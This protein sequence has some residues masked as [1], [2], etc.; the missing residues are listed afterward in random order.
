MSIKTKRITI[1]GI[2]QGVGFR[3]FIYRIANDLGVKGTVLNSSIGV[4][5]EANLDDENLEKFIE[6]IKEKKPANSEITSIKIEDIEYKDFNDF[7]II[8]SSKNDITTVSIPVDLGICKD[9]IND[10][11]DTENPRFLYP[12]TNCTNCGPRFSIIE[13]LPYDRKYT[14]MRKFKMCKRCKNEYENPLDRRF[15]A[16]PNACPVCGPYIWVKTSTNKIIEKEPFDYITQKIISGEVVLIKGLGGFHIACDAFNEKAVLELREIKRRDFK[17]FAIMI[18]EVEKLSKWI[19]ITEEEKKLFY[20]QK[21]PIV[22]F[23]KKNINYFKYVAPLIDSVGIMMPY[24]PL[25]QILFKKLKER[26]FSNPLVMTSG[27][28]KDEPIIKDNEEAIKSFKNFDI[29]LHNRDI[30]NRI[31]DSVLFLDNKKNIRFIRRARGF[32]PEFI[33]INSNYNDFIFAAGGDIKNTFA[34]YRKGEVLLSQHIGDLEIKENRDFFISSYNN[35]KRLFSFKPEIAIIDMHP[36]YYSSNIT[37]SFEFK[38]VYSVQHHISHIF[39]VMAENNIKDNV[40]GIAFDGTGYGN[41]GNVWGGEFFVVKNKNVK[42]IAH[43]EYIPLPGGD[44][45]TKETWRTFLSFLL[46]EI[47][48]AIDFLKKKIEKEKIEIVLNM[49]KQKINSPLSSSLGRIFDAVS[50]IVTGDIISEFEASGP[51]KIEALAYKTPESYEFEIEKNEEIYIIKSNSLRKEI[52]NDYKNNKKELI[53]SKFHNAIVKLIR[54]LGTKL[55]KEYEANGICLSGGV[56]Q[57]RYLLNSILNEFEKSKI[58]IYFNQKVPAN[59]GGI[60]LGQIYYFLTI[61]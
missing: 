46:P 54:D 40:I 18:D 36:N 5:I 14:T 39:S 11:F 23:R 6:L 53:S 20:S 42:R 7:R 43:F 16:Q 22:M 37:K 34:F 26:N 28:F 45:V 60:S 56:F 51:M 2:V 58:K 33:K 30:K 50:V 12:F 3:P 4:I 44:I 1:N 48:F 13:K 57:N 17:P 9:C 41:D 49:I 59:D 24:T 35:I 31:D 21:S 15:H 38:K 8:E 25:H 61:M 10:I 27:N 32:V 55:V 29:L 52:I 47:D 19:I